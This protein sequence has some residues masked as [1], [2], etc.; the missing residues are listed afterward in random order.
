MK[1]RRRLDIITLLPYYIDMHKDTPFGRSLNSVGTDQIWI[2]NKNSKNRNE[3][4]SIMAIEYDTGCV[5]FL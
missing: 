1:L 4:T 5:L 3:A 2:N